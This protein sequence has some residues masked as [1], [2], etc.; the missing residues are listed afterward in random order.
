MYLMSAAFRM[1]I[2]SLRHFPLKKDYVAVN[3]LTCENQWMT[4]VQ[5]LH[6]ASVNMVAATS[7]TM[8]HPVSLNE[9]LISLS[10]WHSQ[11]CY[12]S[13]T[14]FSAHPSRML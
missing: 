13:T 10:E 9:S 5:P 4:D 11:H 3:G 2:S 7:S 12:W 8:A 6:H 1:S 14:K